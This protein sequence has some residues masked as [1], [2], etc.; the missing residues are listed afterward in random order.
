MNCI[1]SLDSEP[2]MN[3]SQDIHE[4]HCELIFLSVN[5]YH[6]FYLLLTKKAELSL[7]IIPDQVVC[8]F[9]IALPSIS[10][11]LSF[12]HNYNHALYHIY[13]AI[14]VKFLQKHVL[15]IHQV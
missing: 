9:M 6:E 15:I 7:R 11:L 10:F 2:I 4:K 8:P 13:M 5:L 12:N 14:D 3:S 1:M